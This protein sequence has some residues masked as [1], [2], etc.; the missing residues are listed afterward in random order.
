[1]STRIDN[2][3]TLSHA[4]A[5]AISRYLCDYATAQEQHARKTRNEA[6]RWQCQKDAAQAR[7]LVSKIIKALWSWKEE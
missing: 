7:E 6:V 2:D 4:D 3:V 5:Q 1:M